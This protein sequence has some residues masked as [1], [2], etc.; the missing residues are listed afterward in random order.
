[1]NIV[2]GNMKR[3]KKDRMHSIEHAEGSLEELD[4]QLFLSK[5]LGYVTEE[6]REEIGNLLRKVSYLLTKFRE[7][8]SHL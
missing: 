2:E 8:V 3:S 5:E 7:G 1:M 4:Y 6:R